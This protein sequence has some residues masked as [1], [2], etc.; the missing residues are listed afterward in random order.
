MAGRSSLSVTGSQEAMDWLDA[1]KDTAT[2]ES[3]LR[4]AAAAGARVLMTEVRAEAP[5]DTGQLTLGVGMKYS[6]DRSRTGVIATYEVFVT[7]DYPNKANGKRGMRKADVARW[8]EYGTSKMRPRPFIRPAFAA[9][10]AAAADAVTDSIKESI[11]N[12]R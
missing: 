11:E 2:G 4:K 8:L 10:K 7:G 3:T 9:K 5:K 6:P 12:G 1:M